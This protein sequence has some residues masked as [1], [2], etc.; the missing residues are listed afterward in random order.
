MKL[1]VK[2]SYI[3]FLKIHIINYHALT[4]KLICLYGP[5]MLP[6][7]PLPLFSLC[8]TFRFYFHAFL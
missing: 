3:V 7:I 2:N 8:L 4:F 5:P 6:F 1:K